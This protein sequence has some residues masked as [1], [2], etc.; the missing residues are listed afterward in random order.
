MKKIVSL[1]VILMLALSVMSVVSFASGEEYT[2]F[3]RG[4]IEDNLVV[5][6]ADSFWHANTLNDS[7]VS[8]TGINW[9]NANAC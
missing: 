4:S 5:N 9:K 7:R 3:V 8:L 6:F 2:D 1:A